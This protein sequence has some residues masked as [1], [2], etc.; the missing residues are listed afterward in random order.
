[1]LQQGVLKFNDICMSW[2]SPKTD[3]VAIFLNPEIEK[4]RK[5]LN[6]NF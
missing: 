6:S 4:F 3:L 5:R 2:S 1:M